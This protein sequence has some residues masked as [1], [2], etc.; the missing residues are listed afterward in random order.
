V[1]ERGRSPACLFD[2]SLVEVQQ[3]LVEKLEQG[4]AW[5]TTNHPRHIL[6]KVLGTA[7]NSN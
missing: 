7:A 3:H 2:I 1:H 5:G 4:F 6:S